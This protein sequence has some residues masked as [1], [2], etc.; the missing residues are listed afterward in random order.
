MKLTRISRS[1]GLKVHEEPL[2]TLSFFIGGTFF[3]STG[4]L[5]IGEIELH[6]GNTAAVGCI[7]VRMECELLRVK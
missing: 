4:P 2:W 1:K 7:F 6:N 5:S 3:L